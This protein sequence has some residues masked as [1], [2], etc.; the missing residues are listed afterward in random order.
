LQRQADAHSGPPAG[1]TAFPTAAF[2][3]AGALW[4]V[5]VDD[6][7]VIVA[8]SNDQG[9]TF[10]PPTIVTRE[11]ESIDANGDA[12]PKIALGTE[13]EIYVAWTRTGSIAYTGDIR[14]ARSL[15]GGR[16]FSAPRTINDDGLITGHRFESLSVNASGDVFLAWIDKRD[17]DAALA[18]GTPYP[19]AALYY[20]WST[21]SGETFS[22]NRKI[23]DNICEC[24]RLA[25][26]FGDRPWPVMVWRDI[27][28]GSIRDHQLLRFD[29]RDTFSAI[30]RVAGDNWRI[31]ACP[32]HGPGFAI[33]AEGG[34]H[35]TWATGDG[36]KGPGSF[37]AR[38]LDGGRTFSEP[39]M[40]GTMQTLA[41]ADVAAL[42][43]YVIL[44]WKE[45][46]SPSEV[47]IRVRTSENGGQ[48]WS[49][50]REVARTSGWSDHPLLLSNGEQ[51]FVS[52]YTNNEGFRLVG[53]EAPVEIN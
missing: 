7:R 42:G 28:P 8:R 27:L 51:V 53:V 49:E 26:E 15:D 45:R 6:L 19:G 25:I 50:P 48:T 18:A 20:T 11:L 30:G 21:D 33:D 36:P 40:L 44:A 10:A 5:W 52:W 29:S 22:P 17:L 37:Y 16:T 32:H 9:V 1:L 4:V 3:E 23:K 34:Y 43:R 2:D 13:G 47:S 12:R 41:H 38:S 46:P 39:M 31:D 35:V 14:F 24:C